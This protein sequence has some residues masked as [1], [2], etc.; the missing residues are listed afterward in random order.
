MTLTD[1]LLNGLLIALVFRQI[2]GR[3]LTPLSLLWPMA[4]VLYFGHT[5]LHGFPTAGNDLWL[6]LGGP[7]IGLALGTLCALHTRVTPD[8]EGRP[9]AKAGWAAATFWV[10]GVG[11]R[12]AFELYASY[13][14]G[15]SVVRFS[16]SH[17]ITSIEAWGTGLILMALAEVIGR[18]GVL[19][20]RAHQ[21]RQAVAANASAPVLGSASMVTTSGIMGIREPVS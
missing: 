15:P 21:V 11:S 10:I 9:F 1:Y 16:A 12:L 2:R 19:A 6:T 17:G 7:L 5:Y 4:S 18:N 13:G 20:W 14:G 8:A 3:R